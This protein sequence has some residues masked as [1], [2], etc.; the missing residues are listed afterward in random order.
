MSMFGWGR[1]SVVLDLLGSLFFSE[2]PFYRFSLF[3][4][5]NPELPYNY[6]TMGYVLVDNQL[7]SYS[8]KVRDRVRGMFCYLSKFYSKT[9]IIYETKDKNKKD[10]KRISFKSDWRH[11]SKTHTRSMGL[12]L[13]LHSIFFILKVPCGGLF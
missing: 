11:E 3:I 1:I 13:K 10:N 12:H 9:R 2:F 4:P 7:Y 8:Q 6:R 5:S